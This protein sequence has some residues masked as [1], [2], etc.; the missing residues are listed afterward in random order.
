MQLDD[1]RHRRGILARLARALLKAPQQRANLLVWRADRDD[2]LGD[3]SRALGVDRAGG[4]N[5]DR[6]RRLRQRVEPRALD[7]E[8]IATEL[9]HLAGEELADHLNRLL[10]DL[11][12]HRRLRPVAPDYVLV[13]R[14]ARADPEIEATGE[15][16]RQGRR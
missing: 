3:A 14:L 9:G 11:Q 6:R 13:E 8:V 12:P 2:A 4:S 5:V 7:V 15:H 1:A 16:R 10:Q